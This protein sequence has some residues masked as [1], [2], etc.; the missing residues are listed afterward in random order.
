MPDNQP[1]RTPSPGIPRIIV[2]T[3]FASLIPLTLGGVVSL[4]G[5]VNHYDREFAPIDGRPFR[6]TVLHVSAELEDTVLQCRATETALR[7]HRDEQ[8]KELRTMADAIV[9]MR[10]SI[11]RLEDRE[12]RRDRNRIP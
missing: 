7:K 12:A 5:D 1:H 10:H 11:N 8:R 3:L 2:Q 9:A 6:D 4:W